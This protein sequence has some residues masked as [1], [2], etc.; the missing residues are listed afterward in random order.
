MPDASESKGLGAAEVIALLAL[1]PLPGEGGMW[2]Q[3]WR[4]ANSNAIYYLMRPGDFSAMHRLDGP[5]LWHHYAGAPV[6]MLLLNPDG[7]ARRP[8]LGTDL[9]AGERP[10]VAV[11]A[12]VWMGAETTGEWSLVGTSMA[13]PFAPEGFELGDG[14]ALARSHPDVAPHI[15]RLVR[16]TPS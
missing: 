7:S 2:A 13:P 8:L 6:Q 5:E 1:E 3:H 16:E 10:V 14:E 15:R 4:D 12:G 11:E 9:L